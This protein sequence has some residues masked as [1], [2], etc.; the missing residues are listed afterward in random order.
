MTQT[1]TD[2]VEILNHSTQQWL[3]LTVNTGQTVYYLEVSLRMDIPILWS[4]NNY[5]LLFVLLAADRGEVTLLS[6]LDLSA[7][8]DTVDH[9]ILTSRLH[10]SFGLRG[11]RVSSLVVHRESKLETIT[12]HT[13]CL[14][15]F[16]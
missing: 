1:P 12:P 3:T 9:N 11:S 6:L 8:F 14:D 13:H 4:Y 2:S 5:I 7:A 10:H 16:K 15:V